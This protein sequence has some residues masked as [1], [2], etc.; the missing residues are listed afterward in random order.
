LLS[1]QRWHR[2]RLDGQYGEA[3]VITQLKLA[4]VYF[5]TRSRGYQLLEHQEI[6]GAL[7]R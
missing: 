3:P 6:Q 5:L 2:S 1:Q 7:A 4:G